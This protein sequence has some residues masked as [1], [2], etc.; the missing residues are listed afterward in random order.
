LEEEQTIIGARYS[1]I[2]NLQKYAQLTFDKGKEATQWVKSVA[3][4]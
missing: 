2:I 1:S 3:I 4:A